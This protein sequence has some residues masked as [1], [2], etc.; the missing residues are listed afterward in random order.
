[1]TDVGTSGRTIGETGLVATE[2]ADVPIPF[3]VVTTN[4]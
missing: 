1:V 3:V 4:E 2:S